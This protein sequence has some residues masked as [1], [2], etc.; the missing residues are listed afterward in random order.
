MCLQNNWFDTGVCPV[1]INPEVSLIQVRYPESSNF[2]SYTK[3][4]A[5][6]LFQACSVVLQT[7]I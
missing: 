4:I 6:G 7:R 1:N 2:K 3:F 5:A